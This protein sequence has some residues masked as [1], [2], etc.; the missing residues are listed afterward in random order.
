VPDEIH[1]IALSERFPYR[2]PEEWQYLGMRWLQY[3]QIWANA[4]E[5]AQRRYKQ[6][7]D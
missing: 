6:L 3:S 2:K 1:A 7:W 4:Q 5:G